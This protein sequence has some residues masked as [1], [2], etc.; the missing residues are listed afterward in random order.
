M[1]AD[2]EIKKPWVTTSIEQEPL[3]L[4]ATGS[5]A[6]REGIPFDTSRTKEWKLGWIEADIALG[7]R[8]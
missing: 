1:D 7:V 8:T 6:R 4:F 2:R 3:P 5:Q